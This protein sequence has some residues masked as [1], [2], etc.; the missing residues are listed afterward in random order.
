MVFASF[1][2]FVP[3]FLSNAYGM[4]A[5]TAAQVGSMYAIGC[6]LAVKFCTKPYN[7]FG[8]GGRSIMLIAMLSTATLLAL[9]QIVHVSGFMTFSKLTGAISMLLWGVSFALPFYIPP[10]LFALKRGGKESSAT[11]A[12]A[13]DFAGFSLLAMFNGYVAGIDYSSMTAWVRPFQLLAACSITSLVTLL[14]AV[15]L[16]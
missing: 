7:E 3:T 16:E 5:S 1:L 8:K 10:S 14:C 15:Q 9:A 6:L 2:L 13:F 12:D 4:S 11:I